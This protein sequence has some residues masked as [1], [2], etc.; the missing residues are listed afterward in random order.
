MLSGSSQ[1]YSE[2]YHLYLVD[3]RVKSR[4]YP[5]YQDDY[6]CSLRFTGGIVR[7]KGKV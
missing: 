7:I 6:R 4:R 1:E 5:W 3:Y 2:T